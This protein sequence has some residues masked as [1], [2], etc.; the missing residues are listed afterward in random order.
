MKNFLHTLPYF[1]LFLILAYSPAQTY[2]QCTCSGGIAATPI[3]YNYVLDTT[4]APSS[5]ISFPKFD[6]SIGILNCVTFSDTLSL[7]SNSHV[8]NTASVPVTYRFLLNVTN[9]INGPGINV[10]ESATRNYGPTL[11]S[12][13]G[14][15]FDQTVYGPDTL[16]RFSNH[17][18]SSSSVVSYIGG[19][20][21][22][23][24][25]YTVN[26]G[27][28]ST[29]GGINYTYQ[30][31]SK[32]WG[33]FSLTYFYCANMLLATNIKNF[34]AVRTDKTVILKWITEN[35]ISGSNYEIES[36][37]DGSN[38]SSVGTVDPRNMTGATTQHTFQYQPDASFS[39]KLYF[40]VK[41]TDASGKITYSAVRMVNMNENTKAAFTIYPNPVDRKVAMQFDRNL[42]GNYVIEV[43]SLSGQRIYTRNIRLNNNNN[44]QFELT[45]KPPS[46]IYYLKITDTKTRVSFSNKLVIQR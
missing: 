6:P 9:D 44:L 43:T 27:L 28:I 25:N 36:S 20:G 16:F 18:N 21:N 17:R 12:R 10:N 40:R 23:D 35:Q 46:G 2:G 37:T 11:L 42:N 34:A 7:I 14:D 4:D 29:Q 26:G 19:S 33:S 31:A 32:Y 24:F 1:L 41:Q 38:F 5:V 39:N 30:I 8:S 22:V 13:A 15:P 3:T 45:N